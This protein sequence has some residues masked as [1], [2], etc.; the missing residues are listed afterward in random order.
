VA[1][2]RRRSPFG[3]LTRGRRSPFDRPGGCA[4]AWWKEELVGGYPTPC[5][6]PVNS[7]PTR[8][9]ASRCRSPR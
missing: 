5:H 2:L 9:R 4:R 6:E 3:S 8:P 1:G 7:R